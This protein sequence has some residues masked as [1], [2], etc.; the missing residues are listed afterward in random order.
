MTSIKAG[1]SPADVSWAMSKRILIIN[2]HPDPSPQ[3]LCAALADAYARGA[4]AAGHEVERINVGS[5]RFKLIRSVADFMSPDLAPD[6]A[7]AQAAL[8]RA[9]HLVIVHPLWLGSAPAVMKG[10]FEQVLRYGD[11]LSDPHAP[12]GLLSGRSARLIVTM[13]MPVAAFE[14]LFGAHGVKSFERGILWLTGVKPV[15]HTLFGGV[16]DKAARKVPAWLKTVEQLGA[17][18]G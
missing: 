9:D 8:A 6:I 4:K 11:A 13:G 12:L 5:L 2:G 3:R 15:R 18:A 1:A 17:R 10:F 14:L 16:G 7:E